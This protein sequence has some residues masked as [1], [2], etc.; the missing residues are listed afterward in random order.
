M[1][2]RRVKVK[3][4]TGKPNSDTFECPVTVRLPHFCSL[5][6]VDDWVCPVRYLLLLLFPSG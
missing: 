1:E 4:E 3:F 6:H 2:T 5:E